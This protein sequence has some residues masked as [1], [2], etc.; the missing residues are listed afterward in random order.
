[1]TDLLRL[2]AEVLERLDEAVEEADGLLPD[3]LLEEAEEQFGNPPPVVSPAKK[4]ER[5]WPTEARRLDTAPAWP[6]FS[7][8]RVPLGGGS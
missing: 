8:H 7:G 2:L 3:D 4:A 6:P 1:M 5:S